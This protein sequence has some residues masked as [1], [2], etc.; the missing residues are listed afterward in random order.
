MADTEPLGFVGLGTMGGV[1]ASRLIEAGHALVVCDTNADAVAALVA[2]GAV[3]AASPAEVGAKSRIVF[4][5]LPTPEVVRSVAAGRDG[6]SA[7][8]RVRM[9]S[10]T[11]PI[12][13]KIPITDIETQPD[14]CAMRVEISPAAAMSPALAAPCDQNHSA[15][16]IS[17]TGSNPASAISQKRN[18]AVTAPKAMIL[19]R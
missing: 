14:I 5:S 16:P 17:P 3:A 8:D 15:P 4:A 7:G 10:S 9:P 1:M 18:V 11:S 6:I 13:V 19:P 12:L 2:K